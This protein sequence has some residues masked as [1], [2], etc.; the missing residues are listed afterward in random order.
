M[1]HGKSLLIG[2]VADYK[3]IGLH[4]Y[5]CIGD[6]YIRGIT[7]AMNAVPILMPAIG[8][9]A[10]LENYLST[11]DGIL[12]SGSPSNIEPHHYQGEPAED[13]EHDPARDATTL[14]L[15]T[16]AIEANIPLLGICRGFQEINVALGGTLLQKVQETDGMMDHREDKQQPVE[17]QYGPAHPVTLEYGGL[18]Q[19]IVGSDTLEVNSIHQQGIETLADGLVV[20]ARAPDGLVEAFRLSDPERFVLAVQFHPEWKV[21]ENP[22]YR[23]IFAAFKAACESRT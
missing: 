23:G 3:M 5:H 15:V 9:M 7:D 11:V 1:K 10:L 8:D 6:K 12:L 19:K 14:P 18:L 20:E 13:P 4:P 17:L 16:L 2:V 21:M 22:A